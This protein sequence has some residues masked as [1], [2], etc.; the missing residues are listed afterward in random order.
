MIFLLYMIAVKRTFALVL[1]QFFLKNTF[2]QNEIDISSCSGR[3]FDVFAI[4]PWDT[5]AC[6]FLTQNQGKIL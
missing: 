5:F 4:Y 6:R 1:K 3:L 2:L